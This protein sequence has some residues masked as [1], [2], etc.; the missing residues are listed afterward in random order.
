MAN[1]VFHSGELYV[2]QSTGEEYFAMQ[3]GSIIKDVIGGGAVNFVQSQKFFLAASQDREGNIWPSVLS[4]DPGFVVV[5]DAH[6]ILLNPDLLRSDSGD[7]FWENIHQNS[8]VG[9]LFID[10]LSRRRFRINGQI[11]QREKFWEIEIEQAFPN[12]PK[13]IQRREVEFSGHEANLAS[14]DLTKWIDQADTI[15]VAS[16]DGGGNLDVSH[17]GGNPGFVTLAGESILRIPD[18]Q[19]NS[20]F[21][22]LGNF[23]ENPHAGLLF[24]DFSNGET[25]QL[26]GKADIHLHDESA[27]TFTGGTNRFWDFQIEKVV[28]LKS[29]ENFSAHL[30]DYSHYNP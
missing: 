27:S 28:F 2:Q 30:I 13:Y 25:M 18:Y 23:H 6:H 24:I 29:L 9:L 17:R 26:I 7:I 19:G 16:S 1:S 20:M 21:N 3:N 22:T 11:I 10:L 5:T 14:H 15:F 4:G 12:C 8:S